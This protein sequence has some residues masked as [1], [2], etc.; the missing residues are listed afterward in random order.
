M[1]MPLAFATPWAGAT[2]PPVAP[3]PDGNTLGG[4]AEPLVCAY[5]CCGVWHMTP[6]MPGQEKLE[7]LPTENAEQPASIS[8]PAAA[9]RGTIAR[10][11]E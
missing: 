3:P 1:V 5:T 10:R 9:A 6:G 11:L 4:I 8:A 2:A 7:E